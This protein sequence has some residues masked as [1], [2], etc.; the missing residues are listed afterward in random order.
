MESVLPVKNSEHRMNSHLWTR[1]FVVG[2]LKVTT[3]SYSRLSLFCCLFQP[4][5][6]AH[7]ISSCQANVDIYMLRLI[8]MQT[9]S[10]VH[11]IHML[12]IPLSSLHIKQ[13]S[14]MRIAHIQYHLCFCPFRASTD[15]LQTVLR[16]LLSSIMDSKQQHFIS[17]V[18]W[19]LFSLNLWYPFLS[20]YEHVRAVR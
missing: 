19:S 20:F 2:G 1:A 3:N 12:L 18:I 11:L 15:I 4:L 7:K 16:L 5:C 6:M 10:C 17:C 9:W 8:A 14:H 13:Y